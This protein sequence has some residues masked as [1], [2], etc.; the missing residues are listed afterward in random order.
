MIIKERN[1]KLTGW[2][3][4]NCMPGGGLVI[5][6]PIGGGCCS[7]AGEITGWYMGGGWLRVAIETACCC[8]SPGGDETE[9]G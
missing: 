4:G 8:M 6:G 1:D 9:I 5:D 2:K 7:I 3:G